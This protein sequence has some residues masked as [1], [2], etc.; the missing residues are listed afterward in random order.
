MKNWFFPIQRMEQRD[1]YGCGIA[2][3][4][5]IC[6]VTYERCRSEFFPNKRADQIKD[7]RTLMVSGDQMMQV[8][9]RFG[10][11]CV[12]RAGFKE[13]KLPAIVFFD[14]QT[15]PHG[16]HAVVW[17]PFRESFLDPGYDWP[18][19]PARYMKNWRRSNY[20]SVIVT[21]RKR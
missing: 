15:P 4:A 2:C 19:S 16:T 14:W 6:G 11:S 13:H 18:L 10:Y 8:I 17:D 20:G 1:D 5:M 21:G 7:D 3:V 12:A 9:R